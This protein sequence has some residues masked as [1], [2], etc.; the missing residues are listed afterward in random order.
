[1]LMPS[2][3]EG[4]GIVIME[5]FASGRL[6]IGSEVGGIPELIREG[7]TGYLVESDSVDSLVE[8]IKWC[9][10]NLSDCKKVAKTARREAEENFGAK[11]MATKYEKI[12]LDIV[13]KKYE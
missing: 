7:Q 11:E 4:L 8:K 12:Y 13:N 3:W 6:V 10:E 5:S 9:L 2:L 1:M